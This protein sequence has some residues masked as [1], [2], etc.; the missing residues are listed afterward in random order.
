MRGLTP[1]ESV[2][3]EGLQGDLK[4]SGMAVVG[5][6]GEDAQDDDQ[7]SSRRTRSND[8]AK[9]REEASQQGM[10]WQQSQTQ[11]VMDTCSRAPRTGKEGVGGDLT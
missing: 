4:D 3:E 10:S 9:S 5:R 6:P 2:G 1:R 8:V 7:N 11:K